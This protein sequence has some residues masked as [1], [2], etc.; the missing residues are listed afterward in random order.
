[1]AVHDLRESEGI[2]A[3]EARLAGAVKNLQEGGESTSAIDIARVIRDSGENANIEEVVPPNR[4][5]YKDGKALAKLGELAWGMVINEQV[6]PSHAA[7]VAEKIRDPDEQVAAL[8]VFQHTPPANVAQARF[9]ADQIVQ[10]AFEKKPV[11]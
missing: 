9:M 8:D 10:A 7:V 6:N 4:A 2:S 11:M 3:E 5:A 1:M